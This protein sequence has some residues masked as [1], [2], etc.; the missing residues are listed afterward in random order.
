MLVELSVRFLVHSSAIG[1]E[2]ISMP[3]HQ[4]STINHNEETNYERLAC[5]LNDNNGTI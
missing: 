3:F 4:P 1:D 5:D 2:M